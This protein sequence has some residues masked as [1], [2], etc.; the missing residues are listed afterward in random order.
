QMARGHVG[1]ALKSDGRTGRGTKSQRLRRGLVVAE[2]ALVLPLL[3][4]AM[5][6]ISTVTRYFTNWPGYDPNRVLVL[7]AVLPE[8]HYATDDSKRRFVAS[9]IDAIRSVASVDDVAIANILPAQDSNVV[10]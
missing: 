1:D 5:L 2:I 9:S 3:V 7:R 10:R 8:P 6:S 4:A